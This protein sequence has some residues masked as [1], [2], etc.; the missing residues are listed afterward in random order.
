MPV[1]IA[2]IGA[3]GR[4]GRGLVELI[5]ADP[6]SKLVSTVTNPSSPYVGKDIGEV[7]GKE[8]IGIVIENELLQS[9]KEADVLIDFS[10]LLSLKAN[11]RFAKEHLRPIVIG[12][13]GHAQEGIQ[14]IEEAAKAIPVL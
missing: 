7:I 5:L 8:P 6:E 4:M 2:I 3:L 10:T 1:K 12:T 11:L 14:A 13:T 9:A